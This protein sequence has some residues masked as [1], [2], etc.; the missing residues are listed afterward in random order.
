MTRSK[1]N[2]S[3]ADGAE[4]MSVA[5][6]AWMRA[7]ISRRSSRPRASIPRSRGSD[8]FA[9]RL[10]VVLLRLDEG[11]AQH[12]HLGHPGGRIPVLRSRRG[13]GRLAERHV[14]RGGFA[15]QDA[16][17]AW[18]RP[19]S[20]PRPGR[21]AGAASAGAMYI[22]VTP[23]ESASAVAERAGLARTE[24]PERVVA[25]QRPERGRDRVARLVEVARPRSRY[26]TRR[27]PGPASR[28]C[29][30]RPRS[31]RRTGS[32]RRRRRR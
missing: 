19:S 23:P 2:S 20:P 29:R 7:G 14:D 8:G 27:R 25:L 11:L 17:E 4:R 32:P 22:V 15:H 13:L 31:P 28:T 1:P 16:L 3:P 21:P 24:G 12:R 6:L 26:A 5:A 30:S 9:A 10:R 18:G